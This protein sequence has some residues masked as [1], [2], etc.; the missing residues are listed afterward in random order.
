MNHPQHI[1]F[2]EKVDMK[3]L[4]S[5]RHRLSQRIAD[6]KRHGRSLTSSVRIHPANI[7]TED[8]DGMLGVDEEEQKEFLTVTQCIQKSL[9]I[10]VKM[11]WSDETNHVIELLETAKRLLLLKQDELIEISKLSRSEGLGNE[12]S[13]FLNEYSN[14]NPSNLSPSNSKVSVK[15]AM[16]L[17]PSTPAVRGSSTSFPAFQFYRKTVRSR[18]FSEESG[19]IGLRKLT[20]VYL[21][22]RVPPFMCAADS[23][24]RGF[25]GIRYLRTRGSV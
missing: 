4:L 15:R 14:V 25:M 23:M 10:I 12:I 11:P 2:D 17:Q 24:E 21:N 7:D 6:N 18:S 13:N 3:T 9:S 22:R 1:W 8:T 19:K 16:K 5:P 20:S